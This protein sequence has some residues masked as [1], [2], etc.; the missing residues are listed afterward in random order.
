MEGKV[1]ALD[2]I[3]DWG[4]E[5]A[6]VKKQEKKESNSAA[7]IKKLAAHYYKNGRA[8]SMDEAINMA[9]RILR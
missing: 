4:F 9:T 6:A 5:A 1:F 2:I 7:S 8:E 3:R